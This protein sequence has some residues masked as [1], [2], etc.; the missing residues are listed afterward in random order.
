MSESIN[1]LSLIQAFDTLE[2]LNYKN[3]LAHYGITIKD[4][5]VDDLK[6]LTKILYD[7]TEKRSIFSQFYV[8]YKIPQ[9]GKEF[10]LL[11]FGNK[12]VINIELKNSSTEEKF[13]YQL[14]RN[15]YYLSFIGKQIYS[16]TFVADEKK[17][18]FLNDEGKIE[19]VDF[20]NLIKLLYEQQVSKLD[21]VNKL[22]NP[23]D[24][25]VSPFNSTEKFIK[26]EYFLTHQQEE[27]KTNIFAIIKDHSKANF[28]SITGS[29][30]TGKT[31]LTYDIAKE[32]MQSGKKVLIIHCGY[33]NEGQ[34]T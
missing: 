26:N 32:I 25:L 29:A 24:Y 31:L 3:F 6:S 4:K 33:L 2:E 21:N 8:S 10:D 12:C 20:S 22:F 34:L 23:S 7:E 1:L 16:F 5:E 30:G 18:Y 14:K 9:I 13:F 27:L 11:R 15:E 19:E 28:I 17:L